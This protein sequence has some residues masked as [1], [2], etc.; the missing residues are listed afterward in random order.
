MTHAE[1]APVPAPF[2]MPAMTARGRRVVDEDIVKSGGRPI[3]PIMSVNM[4]LLRN[5][6]MCRITSIGNMFTSVPRSQDTA[7]NVDRPTGSDYLPH[8]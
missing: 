1:A 7:S 3:W 2:P 6:G 4:L 8:H 5:I